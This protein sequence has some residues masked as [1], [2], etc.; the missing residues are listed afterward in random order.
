M[1]VL[2]VIVAMAYYRVHKL[3]GTSNSMTFHDQKSEILV[4]TDDVKSQL[5]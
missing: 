5:R 1:P 2:P 4:R 3:F